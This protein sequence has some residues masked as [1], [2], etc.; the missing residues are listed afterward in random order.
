MKRS[1]KLPGPIDEARERF[2]LLLIL[3]QMASSEDSENQHFSHLHKCLESKFHEERKE[4][5]PEFTSS[6]VISQAQVDQARSV[7][8]GEK[9]ASVRNIRNKGFVW[10]KNQSFL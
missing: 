3:R 1:N 8:I 10:G 5:A 6:R 4:C 2:C 7:S 9:S